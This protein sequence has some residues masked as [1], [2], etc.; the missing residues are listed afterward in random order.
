M[1]MVFLK[2]ENKQTNKPHASK[3]PQPQKIFLKSW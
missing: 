3:H 2:Y 1:T